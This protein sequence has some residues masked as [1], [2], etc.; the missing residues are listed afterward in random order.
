MV[1]AAADAKPL[2]RSLC[3][4]DH[5]GDR[6]C[7]RYANEITT[8]CAPVEIDQGFHGDPI[9]RYSLGSRLS[10]RFGLCATSGAHSPHLESFGDY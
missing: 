3:A 9:P 6:D 8:G 7:A 5:A 2:S 1:R 10:L 4:R